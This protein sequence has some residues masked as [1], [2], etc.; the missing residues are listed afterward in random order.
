MS[1]RM[2]L[3]NLVIL[4]QTFLKIY[5][6]EVVGCGI[7]DILLNFDNCQPEVVS[8]VISVVVVDPTGVKAPVEF[9][10]SRSNRS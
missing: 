1:A 10:Y 7:F 8:D 4:A 5:R 6:S 2:C 3:S 9:G